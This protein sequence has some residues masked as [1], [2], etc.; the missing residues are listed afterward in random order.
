MWMSL[1][2]VWER[3]LN[4]AMVRRL[5]KGGLVSLVGGL[6]GGVVWGLVLL[7][8]SLVSGVSAMM[9]VVVVFMLLGNVEL[10]NEEML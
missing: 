4:L 2:V 8:V 3:A 6:V 1:E 5:A 7:V 10:E 9:K